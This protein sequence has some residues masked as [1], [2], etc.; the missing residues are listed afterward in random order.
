MKVPVKDD[1]S[2]GYDFR[3]AKCNQCVP[4]AKFGSGDSILANQVEEK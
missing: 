3:N 2:A 4:V 1:I